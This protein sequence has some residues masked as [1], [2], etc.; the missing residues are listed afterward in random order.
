MHTFRLLRAPVWLPLAAL[1]ALLVAACGGGV[2]EQGTGS[3]PQ[4]FASGPIT[5][6]G[7]IIVGGVHYDDSAVTAE[8]EDGR[9]IS[10]G[11]QLGMVVAID[12]A[13]LDKTTAIPTAT[14]KAVTVYSEIVG[15]VTA[16]DDVAGTLTVLGQTVRITP[17][18]AADGAVLVGDVVEVY[19]LHDVANQR[20]TATRLQHRSG[21]SSY[22]L[23][24]KVSQLTADSFHVGNLVVSYSSAPAGL[25]NGAVLR[26]KL[27]R[28]ADGLGRLPLQSGQAENTRQP[29]EGTEVE[30]EGVISGYAGASSFVVRGLTLDAS[31]ATVSPSGAVLANGVTVEAE[32]VMR[33]GVM[34]VS[35][36]EVKS[37]EDGGGSGGETEFEV[38]ST[39]ASVDT[40]AK[41]LVLTKGSTLVDYATARL[42]DL[43][44]AGLVAGVRV[45]V[46]GTLSADG[47]KVVAETIQKED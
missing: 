14:A 20:Y 16:R 9:A 25:A 10:G 24:G 38:T 47:T 29:D 18:P 5:G 41:T 46:K 12:G 33:G 2:S 32:G 39:I 3:Q 44:E 8:D 37:G 6:F 11:L 43:T 27:G 42:K 34:R 28:S 30:V 4:V 21:V 7:S 40:V 19:G 45:E 17:T 13:N 36:L 15:P 31:A 1:A 26:L 22:K 35:K 23:H